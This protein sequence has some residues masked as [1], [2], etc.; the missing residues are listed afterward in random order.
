MYVLP[1][2]LFPFHSPSSFL[3]LPLSFSLPLQ[4]KEF[5]NKSCSVE[6][7]DWILCCMGLCSS[8]GFLLCVWHLS[9]SW[10]GNMVLVCAWENIAYCPL[11]SAL[12][13]GSRN[14][15]SFNCK[16]QKFGKECKSRCPGNNH[17]GIKEKF[18]QWMD[19]PAASSHQLCPIS[20]AMGVL[21]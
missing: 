3:I 17:L 12:G 9:R 6:A 14:I 1:P 11:S 5:S 16:E 18:P 19:P 15:Q 4:H 10:A 20:C 13:T 21:A 7:A 2:S 8:L